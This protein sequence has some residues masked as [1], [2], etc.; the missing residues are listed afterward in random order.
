MRRIEGKLSEE[1]EGK[2][3]GTA[4]CQE[5]VNEFIKAGHRA[6]GSSQTGR[7]FPSPGL[8]QGVV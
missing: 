4:R 6:R 7:P 5:R 1:K 8:G 2:S 3:Q